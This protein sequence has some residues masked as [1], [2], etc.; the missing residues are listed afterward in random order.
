MAIK[1]IEDMDYYEILD[2]KK[3]ASPKEIKTAYLVGKAAYTKN[4]L[5]HYSLI[6]DEERQNMLDRIE[7]AFMVLG[8]PIKRQTYDENALTKRTIYQEKAHFRKSTER[9]IIED[10][11]EDTYGLEF[12]KRVF[13]S[14]KHK[15]D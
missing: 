7:K 10:I 9:M 2:V 13:S 14:S 15:S 12:L 1:K 8:N 6:G 5:A 11:D 3:N 4:S